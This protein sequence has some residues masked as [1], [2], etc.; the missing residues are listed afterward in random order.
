MLNLKSV[1]RVAIAG[2]VL[3]SLFVAAGNNATA[4]PNYL[5]VMNTAYPDLVKKHG[6]DGKLTCAVCHPSTEKSKKKRND[7]GVALTKVL[8]KKNETDKD[9]IKEALTK[10]EKEKNKDDKTFGELIKAG[11]LP[12]KDE[13]AN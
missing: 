6:K 9:K 13:A 5:K 3:F 4:R 11:D 8:G 1:G 2:A 12:G 10:A 7:Y